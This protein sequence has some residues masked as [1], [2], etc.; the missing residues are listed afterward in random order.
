MWS[1]IFSDTTAIVVGASVGSIAGF[2]LLVATGVGICYCIGRSRGHARTVYGNTA[3][4]TNI[5]NAGE[6]QSKGIRNCSGGDGGG[7]C[8]SQLQL[9]VYNYE[10]NLVLRRPYII[11][12]LQIKNKLW[13]LVIW[14]Q[15]GNFFFLSSWHFVSCQTMVIKKLE[16]KC[17]TFLCSW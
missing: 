10:D 17:N 11:S 6:Y 9:N 15:Q 7:R 3:G 4:T 16:F 14:P 1:F 12:S 5:T 2:A 13:Y 8:S